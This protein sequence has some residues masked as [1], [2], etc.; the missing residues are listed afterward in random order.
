M[1]VGVFVAAVVGV[2]VAAVVGVFVAAVVVF[3]VVDDVFLVP[4]LLLFYLARLISIFKI[5]LLTVGF[6][7]YFSFV[8]SIVS[9]SEKKR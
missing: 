6:G 8:I 5:A 7:F 3:V 9:Q 4:F 2:F 1:H